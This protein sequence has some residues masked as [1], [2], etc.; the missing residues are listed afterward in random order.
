MLAPGAPRPATQPVAGIPQ[1]PYVQPAYAIPS[2][3]RK[4]NTI[5]AIAISGV[6]LLLLFIGLKASGVLAFG[7]KAPDNAV[8][9]A[10]GQGPDN[11]LLQS[12]GDKTNP[13]LEVSRVTMPDDIRN[14]LE[15]LARMEKKKQALT[16]TQLQQVRELQSELGG[17]SGL[18]TPED[19]QKMTDPDYNSFPTIDKAT[20]MLNQLQ[21]D[22]VA[23]KKEFDSVPP[24][25]ECKPIAE[26]Y[27]AGLQNIVD[28]FD[29]VEK[30]VSGVNLT[31]QNSIKKSADDVK[32]VGL[33]HRRGIDGEFQQTDDQVQDICDKYQTRK[34]FKIDAHGGSAGLL[35]F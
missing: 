25:T 15:H 10:R 8:L 13:T 14:W 17:A 5:L 19:V 12:R 2:D 9:N 21:P 18:T 20:A 31:D 29:S 27:D 33:R 7:S 22:W 4:R 30:L 1:Q 3:V 35:G 6:L 32:E 26:S 24:P 16:A 28:V 23:L 34:W 11:S